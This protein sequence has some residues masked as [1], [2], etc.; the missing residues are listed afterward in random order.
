M[1]TKNEKLIVDVEG[2][3]GVES[4]VAHIAFVPHDY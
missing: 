1:P 2:V 3:T 4:K